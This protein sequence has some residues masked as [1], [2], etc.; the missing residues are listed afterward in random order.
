VTTTTKDRAPGRPPT[1]RPSGPSTKPSA[2]EARTRAATK[3]ASPAST[4]SSSK[5]ATEST[6]KPSTGK[7]TTGKTATGK[8]SI[9]KPSTG[10]DPRF[11]ARR[12]AVRR[13]EG[14]RRLR[15]LIGMIVV[16]VLIGV[17]YLVT[18]SPLLDVDQV[19][20]VGADRSGVDAVRAVA[21]IE[22]GSPMTDAPI[23]QAHDR[24]TALPW[25]QSVEVERRWP[26]RID[27]R[28]TERAPAAA[29]L[30][31]DGAL[32]LVDGTGRVLAPGTSDAVQVPVIM[33]GSA[34]VAPGS[35]QPGVTGPLAVGRLLTPDLHAWV[36]ALVPEADGTVDLM[37]RKGIR[38]QLGS[39][40]HLSD[41]LVDLATVLTRVDLADIETI[42]VSVV[43]NPV[44][45]R[46]QV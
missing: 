22:E 19:R 34:A 9:G 1:D 4:R 41:K 24:I 45:T 11:R 23:S 46:K 25:V 44:V 18:R 33:I 43:H 37:L 39:Q 20:V 29:L 10:M 36:E 8:A 32:Y 35:Q 15:R 5:P 30:G 12:A 21:G 38:V 27:I 14:R 2:D 17:A 31:A 7:T 16:A 6:S 40:A 28:V 13:G 3:K 26:G 42:D